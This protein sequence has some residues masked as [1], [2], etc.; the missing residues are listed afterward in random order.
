MCAISRTFANQ[1]QSQK[2]INKNRSNQ[3][4]VSNQNYLFML[5]LIVTV[6]EFTMADF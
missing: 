4:T 5:V 2:K 1:I 6:L 3:I